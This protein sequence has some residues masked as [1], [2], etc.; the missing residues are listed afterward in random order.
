[1]PSTTRI[2][3]TCRTAC[4][5]P[6]A[7][8][9]VLAVM[10]ACADWGCSEGTTGV[11][12]AVSANAHLPIAVETAPDFGNIAVGSPPVRRAVEIRNSSGAAIRISHWSVSCEC[13]AVEPATLRVPPGES[14]EIRLTFD[15]SSEAQGFTGGLLMD[16]EGFRD[17]ECVCRFAV[18]AVITKAADVG[19]ADARVEPGDLRRLACGGMW[20]W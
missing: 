16:V 1:M 5:R 13:L 4:F 18:S 20:S 10:A 2:P 15:P 9:C 14:R 3:V 12:G 6:G 17:A 19:Q 11:G 8:A 7:L